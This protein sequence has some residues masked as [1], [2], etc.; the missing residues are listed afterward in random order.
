MVLHNGAKFVTN[1]YPKKGDFEN[2]S[3]TQI[4]KDINWETL[5][6]RRMVAR[7]TMAF[8]ILNNHVI[9]E[10][11]LLPKINYIQPD[12]H[13]KG[14]RVGNENQLVEPQARL[15]VTRATFFYDTPKLWNENITSKQANSKS[16]ETF[17]R[18]FFK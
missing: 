8:K 4:M 2:Y 18:N 15:D 9:L 6:E 13:C 5:E 12:R 14:I 3:I 11:N 17:K 1:K 7:T 16:V 10:P